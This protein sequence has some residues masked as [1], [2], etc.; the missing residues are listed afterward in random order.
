[1]IQS[2]FAGAV[3]AAVVLVAIIVIGTFTYLILNLP[4]QPIAFNP[5]SPKP[6]VNGSVNQPNGPSSLKLVKFSS[7]QEFKDYIQSGQGNNYYGGIGGGGMRGLSA[8]TVTAQD[9]MGLD[10]GVPTG[11]GTA[12]KTVSN[13][14]PERVSTTNVQVGGID[15]PDILKTDGKNIY[16]SQPSYYYIQPQPFIRAMEDESRILPPNDG[17]GKTKVIA[18]FPPADLA[19]IGAIDKTGDLLVSNNTLAV[20]SGNEINAFNVA[21][22]KK[23]EKKWTVTLDGNN[24]IIQSRLYQDKIYLV[25]STYVDSYSPCPLKLATDAAGSI[26]VPCVDIYHPVRPLPINV[27]YTAM[28]IDLADRKISQTVSFVGSTDNSV[29]YMSPSAMYVT[30]SYTTDVAEFVYRF[31]SQEMTD[32]MPPAVIEKLKKLSQYDIS[33]QSKLTE[34]NIILQEFYN[35]LDND[36]R[37]RVENEGQNKMSDYLTAHRR[38]LERTGIVKIGLS[39]FKIAATGDV[40]GRPLNQF[41]LYEYQNHLRLATTV[42]GGFFFGSSES[43]SDVN[44]LDSNLKTVGSVQDLGKGERIYS[45]RFIED[46]GYVVTFRQTD[47]FYVIDLAKP[48]QPQLKGELKIPGFSSYLH[49]INKDKII[50]VGQDQGR[51]KVSLFDV[52]N[53]SDPQEKSK[54]QLDDYWSEVLSTHHAFLLDSK[55]QIFFMPG[56]RGGYVFSYRD[57]KL[58][59][60]RAVSDITAKRALYLNDYLYIV[61][62]NQIVVLNENDWERVKA[63]DF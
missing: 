22:P 19:E 36:E 60:E 3:I 5:F 46:K 12:D 55:H 20:I 16:Y 37:L 25:T 38:E 30:Y 35:S 27:T 14:S 61:G 8:P 48:N 13:V 58:S 53:P 45:V 57:D 43:V 62:D 31:Y 51:V 32:L 24:Q 41:S 4:D 9:E 23:P 56:S 39:D 7:E 34:L 11:L 17:Y 63:L 10:F 21:D 28:V 1:M 49:P 2:R 18:A 42:S 40:A 54:Y 6:D 29:V 59:L 44:V 47:P 26:T 33:N 52:T 50:A 15:E